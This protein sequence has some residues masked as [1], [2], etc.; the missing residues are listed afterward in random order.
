MTLDQFKEKLKN[1][2]TAIAFTDTMQVIEDNYSFT[3]TA[4]K[5]G[6]LENKEGEN[7]GSCKLFAF[8]LKQELSK[9]E[10]LACFGDYY[11]EDVLQNPNGDGHLNIRNFMKTGFSGLAFNTEALVKK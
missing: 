11:W 3:P 9:E 6:S 8:A 1:T 10:T 2:P 7:S 4:F 5:N